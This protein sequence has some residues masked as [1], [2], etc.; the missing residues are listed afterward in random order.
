M[1]IAVKN[2]S[3]KGVYRQEHFKNEWREK[4]VSIKSFK[5]EDLVDALKWTGVKG[6][7][8]SNFNTKEFLKKYRKETDRNKK[9]KMLSKLNLE[10]R[11]LVTYQFTQEELKEHK[12]HASALIER[13]YSCIMRHK[14]CLDELTSD[15]PNLTKIRQNYI[16]ID[17]SIPVYTIKAIINTHEGTGFSKDDFKYSKNADKYYR[18]CKWYWNRITDRWDTDTGVLSKEDIE[19]K[20][21]TEYH[22]NANKVKTIIKQLAIW[23]KYNRY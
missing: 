10:E 2:S 21:F 6:I 4:G 12:K 5:K 8:M 18:Q 15:N 9:I 11:T 23:K 22:K 19:N 1:Y 17:L 20:N 13:R 7:K 16:G 3:K 14:K